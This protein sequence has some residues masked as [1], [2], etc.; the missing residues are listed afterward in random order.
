MKQNDEIEL[1]TLPDSG[2]WAH[3]IALALVVIAIAVIMTPAAYHRISEPG[4]VSRKMIT[5]SS[6]LISTAMIPLAAGLALDTYVVFLATTQSM[7]LAVCS[8]IGMLV[9]F[10]CL[11]F[12][13]PVLSR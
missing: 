3:L 9:F 8:A 1:E 2:I 13:F 11:W 5:F 7:Q 4:Q 6:R 12:V 10:I